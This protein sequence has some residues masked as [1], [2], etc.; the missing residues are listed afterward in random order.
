M[1]HFGY[2][3]HHLIVAIIDH[4]PN[5]WVMWKMGTF[6]DPWCLF[7]GRFS[8]FLWRGCELAHRCPQRCNGDDETKNALQNVSWQRFLGCLKIFDDPLGQKFCNTYM[9]IYLYILIYIYIFV[10]KTPWFSAE[11]PW[12]HHM[13]DCRSTKKGKGSLRAEAVSRSHPTKGAVKAATPML[14]IMFCMRTLRTYVY[15]YLQHVYICV[16][17]TCIHYH[18]Y[19]YIH[20]SIYSLQPLQQTAAALTNL[21]FTAHCHGMGDIP[22]YRISMN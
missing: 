8:P 3:G 7:G 1:S 17:C 13:G 14:L 11:K 12:S 5:G 16:K 4:I 20:I 22:K 9:Y 15:L 10:Q 21:T 2:I 18:I 19:I 6:N